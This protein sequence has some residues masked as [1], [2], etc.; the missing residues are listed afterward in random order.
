MPDQS[1]DPLWRDPL[2]YLRTR[3]LPKY[4]EPEEGDPTRGQLRELEQFM[5]RLRKKWKR[6]LRVQ[7][8]GHEDLEG[9]IDVGY[10]PGIRPNP[11]GNL[12]G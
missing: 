11:L 12:R 10:A 6:S 5:G 8:H 7:Y 3:V 2:W 4:T 1:R 9:D